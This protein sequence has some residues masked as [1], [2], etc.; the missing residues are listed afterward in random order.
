MNEEES[1]Y[2]GNFLGVKPSEF[3]SANIIIFPVPYEGTVT[4]GSGTGNGPK[5]IIEASFHVE[6]YDDELDYEPYLF[7]IHTLPELR[8]GFSRPDTMFRAVQEKGIELAES[9]KFIIMLGGEHSITSGMVSAFAKVYDNISVLQLDAHADLRNS[10]NGSLYNHACVMRRIL[11]Y[12]PIVQVGI[13][14]LSMAEKRFIERSGLT[15]FF[16]KDIHKTDDWI[17]SAID[18]LTENVY[19]TI[20]LDVLDPSI[21]P[22]VGTPEPDGMLWAE[23]MNFIKKLSE[24]RKIIGCDIVELSPQTGNYAPDFLS[25]KLLYK[26]IG[27]KFLAQKIDQ[28]KNK[29][30][31]ETIIMNEIKNS[32]LTYILQITDSATGLSSAMKIDPKEFTSIRDIFDK[33]VKVID[34]NIMSDKSSKN[35]SVI[36]DCIYNIDDDGELLDIF[37][38]L[39][40][41]QYGDVVDFDSEP[42]FELV[43][44]EDQSEFMLLDLSIDRTMI[45]EE[46]NTYG[47]NV[48]KWK[49][50]QEVFDNF[51]KECVIK[52]YGSEAEKIIRLDTQTEKMKFLHAVAKR[53]WEADFELYSRFIGEK[54]RFKDPSE[55]LL[56]IIAGRGGTCTEKSSAMKMITD[57]YGFES[58]YLLAGPGAKG[59]FPVEPLR[60]MLSTF[61]F[62]LGKKYMIYWQHAALLYNVDGEDVMIDVTNGNV[63]FL[64]LTGYEIEELLRPQNKKSVKVRM[65]MEDEDFYYHVVPQDIPEN[66]ILAMQDWIEDVDLINVF[67]DGLGL[68]ITKEYFVWPLMYHNDDDKLKEYDWWLEKKHEKNLPAVEILD[69][70][71]VPGLVASEFQEKYPQKFTDIIESAEYL[72]K[73]YNESY[74]ESKDEPDYNV[75]FI[76]VKLKG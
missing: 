10:Y 2:L 67:D 38:G 64:F 39:I 69:N 55:T 20:D 14:S 7:G 42:R 72:A 15:V 56:N 62:T 60:R 44:T 16:M 53:I 25:A 41:R 35:L 6:L 37:E 12:C 32:N 8:K 9:G 31:K 49:K 66:L 73:R 63:P 33:Y 45:T 30:E 18:K 68:L 61:D 19:L 13:R 23:L 51:V 74:K 36:Q 11:D 48:R 27:Y 5:A 70:Y 1:I 34:N 57:I 58:E 21:M 3:N 65:V 50:N 76:F 4:Y 71:S 29:A 54:I 43:R 24:K 22:S 26:V 46:G 17:D 59:P 47:Y 28:E 52:E 40:I 75:A